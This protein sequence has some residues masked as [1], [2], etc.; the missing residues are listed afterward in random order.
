MKHWS[1]KTLAEEKKKLYNAR[2]K[3][4]KKWNSSKAVKKLKKK[5]AKVKKSFGVEAYRDNMV[6]HEEALHDERINTFEKSLANFGRGSGDYEISA[7]D[8]SNKEASLKKMRDKK[9]ISA[10]EYKEYLKEIRKAFLDNQMSLF[11]ADKVGYKTMKKNLDDYVKAGKITWEEYYEYLEDLASEQLDKEQKR[12]EKLEKKNADT[13]DLA[14]SWIDRKI[15]QL[16]KENEE[17]NKQ[18]ELVEKQNELEKAR[19]Q[20]VKVYRKGIGFVYEQDTQAV[21][22]ATTALQEYKKEVEKSPELQAW[23]K[24][25]DIFE[26]AEIDAEI[27]NF[28]V[29]AGDTFESLF[30]GFGTDENQWLEWVKNNL[31]T[32]YGY[33]NLFER[34]DELNGWEAIMNFLNI[35]GEVDQAKVNEFINNNRF[36]S[37]SLATPAGFARVGEQGYE[38]ALFGKGD[39]VMPHNVSENLMAWGAHSPVEYAS[40]MA[41]TTSNAYHFDSLVLPNV[42]D[43]NSL[44]NE[45]NNLPNRALQYSKSRA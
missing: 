30:G 8:V 28:E 10:E 9:Q 14:K 2:I 4:L 33:E 43:A 41:S 25:R 15:S 13:Y 6:E 36:A 26:N 45:L 34:M 20:R 44:L 42:T 3:K 38:I 32:K 18:N 17:T 29:L 5:G 24:I 31:A 12:L 27:R 16:E 22:E 11:Q 39:A 1:D 21:K 19:T 40:A 35:D 23:E 7:K 37:G